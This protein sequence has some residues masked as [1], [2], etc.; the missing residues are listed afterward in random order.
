MYKYIK[1]IFDALL[2]IIG[3]ILTLPIMLIVLL[4][5]Y[6][7]IKRPLIDIRIPREGKNKKPFYMYKIRTRVYDEKGNSTYTKTSKLIDKLGLNEL[8][9]LFNILKGEMSFIGPRPFICGEELPKG[10]I[11]PKR[12]LVKPGVIGLAQSLGGRSLSYQKTLECDEIYYNNFGFVQDCK[13]FFK[14]IVVIIK[15]IFN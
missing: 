12:Y 2:S 3:I 15:N 1:R 10:K 7:D 14:S 8:P 6:I 11:S 5:T 9:Q 4:I 13:I